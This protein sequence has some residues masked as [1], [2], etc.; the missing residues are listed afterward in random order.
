MPIVSLKRLIE[1]DENDK[2]SAIIKM[3]VYD[4][5]QEAER[6]AQALLMLLQAGAHGDGIKI[7]TRRETETIKLK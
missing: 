3:G 6:M 2:F 5:H 7:E 1:K 4:T